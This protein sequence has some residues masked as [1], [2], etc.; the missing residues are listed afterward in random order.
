MSQKT[1][2][3]TV[4]LNKKARHLYELSEF[5]EAGIVLTGPEVKSIRAGKVNFIDSYVDF[6]QGEAWLV[7]LHIAPYANAGYV[8]QE[9]DRARKLLLHEREISKFAG[10]VAQQGLT[11]VPVRLYFKRG[12]IK[13]E[14]ALGKGKKLHDHRETLKRRAEERDMAR[15]LS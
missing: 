10:L 11:V 4:A 1:P 9:P 2:P 15:E 7:S 8:S 3:S 6:R 14:I 12:K 5:T 13:V